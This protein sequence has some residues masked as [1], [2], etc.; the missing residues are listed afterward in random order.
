MRDKFMDALSR[1]VKRDKAFPSVFNR[2][3]SFLLRFTAEKR[4]KTLKN[5]EKPFVTF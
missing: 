3:K 1:F 5:A 2:F 4:L